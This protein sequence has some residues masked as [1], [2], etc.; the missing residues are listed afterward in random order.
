LHQQ[1]RSEQNVIF[2]ANN[3]KDIISYLPNVV[4]IK[5]YDGKKSKNSTIMNLVLY[6]YKRMY[7]V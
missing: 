1:Y 3:L 5:Q 6:L 7:G 2:I 4:P